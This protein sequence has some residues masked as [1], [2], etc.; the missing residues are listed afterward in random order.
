MF[1]HLYGLF[2]FGENERQMGNSEIK[3]IRQCRRWWRR[4]LILWNKKRN[5]NKKLEIFLGWNYF[6][7]YV[8]H[9][10]SLFLL[11]ESIITRYKK[12]YL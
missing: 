7:T 3:F 6:N 1:R 8:V 5:W 10:F 12:K 4:K 11:R 9:A 2:V